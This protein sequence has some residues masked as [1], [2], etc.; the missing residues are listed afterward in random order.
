MRMTAKLSV[1]AKVGRI[2]NAHEIRWA[3]G[4]SMLLYFKGMVE[5]C[6]DIDVM[7]AEE[8]AE[9]VRQLLCAIG[10]MKQS[11]QDVRYR[12]KCFMEFIIDGVEIDVMAGFTI[13]RDGVSHYFPL[14]PET[15]QDSVQVEGV[16]VPLQSVEEWREYYSLMG[17][18][19]RVQLIDLHRKETP[20][21]R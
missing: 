3:V 15:L 21:K 16:S 7:I 1:L 14:Q 10:E 19:A 17:R 11:T 4:A 12:T 20:K 8:D 13:V 2:L 6:D 18:I 5:E 9:R